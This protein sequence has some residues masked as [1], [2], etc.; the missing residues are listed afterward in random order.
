MI[1]KASRSNN[2]ILNLC[3]NARDAMARNDGSNDISRKLLASGFQGTLK[4]FA[5]QSDGSLI[6]TNHFDAVAIAP[7]FQS[8]VRLDA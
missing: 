5:A 2:A 1:L 4:L 7:G 8:A 6:Q 3:I